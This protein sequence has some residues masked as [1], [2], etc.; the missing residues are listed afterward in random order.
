[1]RKTIR[2]HSVHEA[3]SRD[4][5]RQ[6]MAERQELKCEQQY[7]TLIRRMISHAEWNQRADKKRLSAMATQQPRPVTTLVEFMQRER[8]KQD[9]I[10]QAKKLANGRI[11][12]A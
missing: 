6:K 4:H 7:G 2:S 5:E 12:H 1:M 8:V 9:Q 10:I 3:V 11:R